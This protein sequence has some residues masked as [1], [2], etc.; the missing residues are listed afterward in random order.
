MQD[1]QTTDE[2]FKMCL[3]GVYREVPWFSGK[4]L[5]GNLVWH[6]IAHEQKR[7]KESFKPSV[8][9]MLNE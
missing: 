2:P 5:L 6:L 4:S 8:W 7:R 1:V 3:W 9:N